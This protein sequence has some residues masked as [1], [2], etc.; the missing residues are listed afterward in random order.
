MDDDSIWNWRTKAV[1]GQVD[2]RNV[3]IFL[4]DDLGQQKKHWHL[5]N[6]WPTKWMGASFNATANEVAIET[7][8][9]AHEGIT[10]T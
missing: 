1:D 10:R 4:L 8:E 6:A 3:T 9:L 7:L 5:L 2:R